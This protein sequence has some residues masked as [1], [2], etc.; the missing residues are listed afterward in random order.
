MDITLLGVR[1]RTVTFRVDFVDQV[2]S[3]CQVVCF[4]FDCALIPSKAAEVRMSNH[5]STSESPALTNSSNVGM[6]ACLIAGLAFFAF[7]S[8]GCTNS[9]LSSAQGSS[10]DT[11]GSMGSISAGDS[12]G[13]GLGASE[14]TPAAVAS[15]YRK[16]VAT[17][18]AAQAAKFDTTANASDQ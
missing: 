5:R 16:Q 8:G 9:W 12:L 14:S 4:G 15:E 11:A 17:Q 6:I 18:R 13:L 3:S 7:T 2:L 1:A 10:A